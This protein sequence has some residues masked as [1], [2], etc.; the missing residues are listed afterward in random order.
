MRSFFCLPDLFE[1]DNLYEHL[2]SVCLSFYGNSIEVSGKY[3]WPI[4]I[5]VL[6]FTVCQ[7]VHSNGVLGLVY[8]LN[9]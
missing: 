1:S 9:V 6:G 2:L 5:K 3:F 4:V 8:Q 7:I